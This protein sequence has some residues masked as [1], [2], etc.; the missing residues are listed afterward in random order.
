MAD[1]SPDLPHNMSNNGRCSERGTAE[2]YLLGELG[3]AERQAFEA[4]YF[5]CFSCGEEVKTTADFL[6]AARVVLGQQRGRAPPVAPTR[7][8]PRRRLGPAVGLA[9]A[10][11]LAVVVGYQ[12]LVEIPGLRREVALR[13]RPRAIVATVL[14]PA[15]RGLA[16]VVRA[17]PDQPYIIVALEAPEGASGGFTAELDGEAGTSVVAPWRVDAP[18]PGEPLQLLIPTKKLASG[19]YRLVLKA[20]ESGVAAGNKPELGSYSFVL[21]RTRS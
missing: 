4:H 20:T 15:S 11:A 9:A 13:D 14:R 2:R 18:G 3:D 19:S 21:E 8:R 1:E 10:A 12:A 5:E 6:E 17:A 7:P 16:P